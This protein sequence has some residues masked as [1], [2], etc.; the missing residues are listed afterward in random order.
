MIEG[1][2]SISGFDEGLGLVQTES[3]Y[4]FIDTTGKMVIPPKYLE[5]KPFYEGLA[6]VRVGDKWG[7]IDR[8]GELVIPPP[9]PITTGSMAAW[10]RSECWSR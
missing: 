4:G 1:L 7:F 9:F 5:V 2:L 8:S 10:R 3:G 6:A